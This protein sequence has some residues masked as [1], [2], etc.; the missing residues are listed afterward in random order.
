[1]VLPNAQA[2]RGLFI[3]DLWRLN[4]EPRITQLESCVGL[5]IAASVPWR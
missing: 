2:F 3:G 5:V 4:T 1:M